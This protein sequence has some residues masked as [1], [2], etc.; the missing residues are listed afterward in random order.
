MIGIFYKDDNANSVKTI[1]HFKRLLVEKKL[2]VVDLVETSLDA[3]TE[4]SLELIVVFGGDGTVLSAVKLALDKIPIVAINT[5]TVGFLTSFEQDELEPLVKAIKNKTLEFSERRLLAV[6]VGQESFYALN[7]AVIVKDYVKD[8]HGGCVKLNVEIDGKKVD[9]YLADGLILSTAT[10]STAYAL[11]AGAPIITPDLEAICLAPICP[12]SLHSRP[13]VFNQK[14]I[15]IVTV[16]ES[17]RGCALY[18][19]G[20]LVKTLEKGEQVKVLLA[21]KCIKICDTCENFFER[22]SKKISSWSNN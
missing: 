9:K 1:R 3:K 14:S 16:D 10:G 8:N 21:K 13:I 4:K 6:K 5:G 7:D 20:E 19:D 17:S 22:L 15:A 12:H 11:S 18:V 2:D